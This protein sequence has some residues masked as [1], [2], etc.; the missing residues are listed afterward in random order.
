[1]NI[2]VKNALWE[3]SIVTSPEEVFLSNSMVRQLDVDVLAENTILPRN[4]VTVRPSKKQIIIGGADIIY[5]GTGECKAGVASMRR[6]QASLLRNPTRLSSY[7]EITC[8]YT[9]LV[10]LT[11][12]HCGLSSLDWTVV[13]TCRVSQSGRGLLPKRSSRSVELCVSPTIP[14]PL[15]WI[16]VANTSAMLVR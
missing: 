6:T 3:R 15:F 7:R 4:D 10:T 5:C 8:S 1:M 12:I 16:A 13:P 9:H 11:P 14:M 2:Y